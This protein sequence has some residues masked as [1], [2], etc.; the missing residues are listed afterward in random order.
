MQ[1]PQLHAGEIDISTGLAAR[2]IAEQFPHWAGLPVHPVSS[3]GTE[4]V[5]Y[6]LG[7]DLVIR[8]P[9]RPGAGIDA[10]LTH[11]VLSR[12][13]PFLPV[14][15]PA[16]IAEGA[17]T[18]EYPASWGVLRWLDGDTPVESH[19]AEPG[20]LAADLAG[21]LNALWHVDLSTVDLAD[22]SPAYRG[23]PL[24]DQHEFTIDSI[25]HLR[26]LID[27]DAARA[28]WEHAARLPPWDGPDTWIHADM[29]PGNIVTRNGRLAARPRPCPVHGPRPPGLLPRHQPSHGR[30]RPLHHPRNPC[31]LCSCIATALGSANFRVSFPAVRD[32]WGK[33]AQGPSMYEMEGP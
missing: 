10:I 28:I 25:E 8:L 1:A 2:L 4:C 12:L 22:R 11:G 17:P 6:R 32:G 29:M 24:T 21:F 16:L 33:I 15:V 19:L 13:A 31:R 20:L 9:R 30:Q 5:L 7:D 18:A 14:A 3:A 26:G 23:G 27:T